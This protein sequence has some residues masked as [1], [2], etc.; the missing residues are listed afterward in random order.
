[1]SKKE[2]Y[3]PEIFHD[4]P[5]ENEARFQY[6]YDKYHLKVFNYI[7]KSIGNR[8]DALDLLQEVF[9]LFYDRIPRLD[10]STSRIEAWLLRVAR[11][12]ALSYSRNKHRKYTQSMETTEPIADSRSSDHL[13]KKEMQQK[14]DTFLDTL[15]DHERTIFILHK[16]EGIKYKDLM[17]I[18]EISPRTLKRIVAS[19]LNKMRESNIFEREDLAV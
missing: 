17:N 5:E 6:I 16:L 1:M 18:F 11:N 19:V 15:N 13:E 4:Q 7:A 14:F 10:T 2:E 12:L 8:E 3:Q 9:L